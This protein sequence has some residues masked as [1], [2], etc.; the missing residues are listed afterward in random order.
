VKSIAAHFRSFAPILLALTLTACTDEAKPVG[1]AVVNTKGIAVITV[2]YAATGNTRHWDGVVE[3]VNQTT[4]SAQTSGRVAEVLVDVNDLVKAGQVLARFS[5]VEQR[6][7]Q[8]RALAGLNAM[9]AQVTEA[10]ADFKR[11]NEIYIKRLISK[12]QLDQSLA[13]RDAARAQLAAARA[14]VSESSQQ[15]DYTTIR[16]P[17]NGVIGQRH[18]QAGETVAPGQA[19]FGMNSPGQ[20]RVRISLPQADAGVLEQNKHAKIVL[21]TGREISVESII[22]FPDADP[23]TH[24]VTVRLMLPNGVAGLKPGMTIK[25]VLPAVGD[26]GL[27][28]PTSALVQRSEVTSV[29]VVADNSIRL[30]QIRLGNRLGEQVQVLAGLRIGESIASDPLAANIRLSEQQASK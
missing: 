24:T 12:A 26:Q 2:A 16:A 25:A 19:I 6:S 30:R 9:Q 13:R 15:L 22:V 21:N 3:A 18:V 20:L 17:F 8:N 10:D 23:E 29:Y 1:K 14:Q 27:M 28:I 4:V 7:G 11:L 5:D